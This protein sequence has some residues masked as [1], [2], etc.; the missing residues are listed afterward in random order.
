MEALFW[1][2]G[3]TTTGENIQNQWRVRGK[4]YLLAEED[5]DDTKEVTEVLERYMLPTGT[6]GRGNWSWKKE[7]QTH[8]GNMTPA[9][10]GSFANPP[11]GTPLGIPLSEI[12]EKKSGGG[13]VLVK[14]SKINNEN[15]MDKDGLAAIAR[16]N[17]RVGVI[18]PEVVER[19]DLA[20][21][22]QKARRWVWWKVGEEEKDGEG[23]VGGWKMEETWP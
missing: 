1:I 8:F 13:D 14:G 9:L 18:I 15:V 7:V 4:C 11:P 5:V 3:D 23:V 12:C 19:L 6:E 20:E 22:D 16:R 17:M 10:R 2:A 21:D